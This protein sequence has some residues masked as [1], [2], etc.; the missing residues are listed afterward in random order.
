MMYLYIFVIP[1]AIIIVGYYLEG[2]PTKTREW[3]NFLF[4]IF[5]TYFT[6]A[7]LLYYLGGENFI[8][9]GLSFITILLFTIPLGIV[10]IPFKI[11][12]FLKKKNNL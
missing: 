10:I 7:L 12:Y 9:V 6:Y 11:Y 4:K 5:K 3:V 8:N 1:I 2:K